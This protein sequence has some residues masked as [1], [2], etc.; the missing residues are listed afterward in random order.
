MA[1]T[2]SLQTPHRSVDA[3]A[4]ARPPIALVVVAA[5]LAVVMLL[6]LGYVLSVVI[7]VGWGTL[8]PLIFRPRVGELLVNTVLLV[9]FGVPATVALGVG[10]AWLVE[11]T[12]LPYRRFWAVVLVAPLAIPAFVSS[13]GWASVIPSINGLSGGLLVAVLAY[14]PLVYLPAMATIRGLDPALEESARSLG[15]SSW[16]VFGR[17]V[18]PQLRL[19]I[20]GGGLIVAL[21]LLAEY[22]AFAFIRFDTFT[23]AIVVQYQST[24]AG[25]AA[26]ALGV[27]L[28]ALCLTLLVTEATARGRARYARVGSGAARTPAPQHLG[29]M[30]PLVLLALT[31]LG[32]AAVAVPLS[33]VLRWLTQSNSWT[34]PELVN[35]LVQTVLLAGG[36]A[37]AAVLVALPI[38]WL[39]ARHPGRLSRAVEGSSY[40]AASLPA[41]IVALAL[42]TVTLRVVPSLYQT[43]FTVILAYVIIFLP[44]ALVPL[45]AGIAQAPVPLEEMAR[46]LGFSPLVARFRV[47]LPL[48]V[49]S[50]A[51]GAALVALGAANELTATLLLAPN[52]TR[53]LATQFW[54]AA[55]AIDYPAAAPYGLL[56]IGLSV[57]AVALMFAQT[58]K[59]GAQ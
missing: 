46:S 48:L 9:L 58:R 28:S 22:G 19:A 7:D 59:W 21:H 11:R 1:A 43:A 56:L 8:E 33:S 25:P 37:L 39:T 50:L 32:V 14:Y 54:S 16:A 12:T 4:G 2:G 13:Y 5:A 45:R 42:V 34:E 27:V 6:P 31:G 55:S 57:P 17:V 10:G 49:P 18:L 29:A 52:G 44:R 30:T 51:A 20:L 41:I 26:G 23:T 53:T 3:G 36:G 47:T 35:A 38:A 24:F 15:L 40:V